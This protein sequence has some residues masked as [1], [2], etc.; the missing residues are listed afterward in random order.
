MKWIN[1]LWF[2]CLFPR[3]GL[4]A[5]SGEALCW[6]QTRSTPVGHLD[7]RVRPGTHLGRTNSAT[8]IIRRRRLQHWSWITMPASFWDAWARSGQGHCPP[9]RRRHPPSWASDPTHQK[10]QP[11]CH[12][13]Q[14][15]PQRSLLHGI[16]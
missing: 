13:V 14:G 2:P 8:F 11:T 5:S 1:R 9:D 7:R 15:Y 16:A 12:K 10:G 6:I 4:G 3:P